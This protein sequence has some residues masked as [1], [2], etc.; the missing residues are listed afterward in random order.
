MRKFGL[1][2][3]V[4]RGF[5]MVFN[6][7]NE[8]SLPGNRSTGATYLGKITWWV[9][10]L[11]P[12]H[13]AL[14]K[15][16]H[17]K[18]EKFT[19]PEEYQIDCEFLD[20]LAQR[21]SGEVNL[22]QIHRKAGFHQWRYKNHPSRQYGMTVVRVGLKQMALIFTVEQHG[23]RLEMVVVDV[24]GDECPKKNLIQAVVQ[25]AKRLDVDFVALMSNKLFG[26]ER[27]WTHGFIKKSLKNMVVLPLGLGNH[28]KFC[29]FENWSMVAGLH[30]S[31]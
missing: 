8:N 9:R 15:L 7:P 22:I 5:Q 2:V 14:D 27:L 1:D 21:V 29:S 18:A 17:L 24:V 12:V 31:I 16:F 26:L 28:G 11:K 20:Q 3:A 25:T 23:A 19:L 30:D 6:F 4:S 10:I 13:L